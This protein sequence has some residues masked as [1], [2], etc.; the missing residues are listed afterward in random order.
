MNTLIFAGIYALGVFLASVS[1]V[2]LKR[3]AMKPHESMIAE[4][5]NPQ[6]ILAYSI[7]FVTTLTT[8]VAYTVIPVSLGSVLEATSYLYVMAFGALIFNERITFPKI[9]AIGL[10]IGGVIIFAL[11]MPT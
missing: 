3:E 5:L 6:V 10:I 2:L 11:G 8:I 1:Q 4:S 9:V 7:F